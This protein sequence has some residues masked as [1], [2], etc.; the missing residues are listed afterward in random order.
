MAI[1]LGGT[2][3]PDLVL[4]TTFRFGSPAVRSIFNPSRNGTPLIFEQ[5]INYK[6]ANLVGD[7]NA[8]WIDHE[9]LLE[10]IALAEVPN[11]SYT[12]SYEGTDYTVYFRKWDQPVIE[13]DP[14]VP[15]PNP[16]N[17]DWYNNVNIKLLV[18]V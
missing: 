10:L 3:L 17:S 11:S 1:S 12:L 8:G 6:E 7:S 5:N 16:E 14:L 2:T 4:D 18:E 15:R 9:T 13:A